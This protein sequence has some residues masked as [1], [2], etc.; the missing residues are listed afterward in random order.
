MQMEKKKKETSPRRYTK[1]KAVRAAR[2]LRLPPSLDATVVSLAEEQ[3]DSITEVIITL[4]QEALVARSAGQC[5]NPLHPKRP[6][7]HC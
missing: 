6:P 2:L 1:K 4:L 7:R 3:G 5:Q